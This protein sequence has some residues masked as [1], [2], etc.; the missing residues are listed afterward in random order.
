MSEY[1]VLGLVVDKLD[2]AIQI[3]SG[4]GLQI[5]TEVF[6]AEVE[7]LGPA[8]LPEM[9]GILVEGGVCCSIGD[10][11]DSVYQG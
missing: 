3:L 10:V 4:N 9:V 6:G 2:R 8:Q 1:S 5:N 7:I 11:I